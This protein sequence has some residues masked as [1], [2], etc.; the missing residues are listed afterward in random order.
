[1]TGGAAAPAIKTLFPPDIA[2][3]ADDPP[4]AGAAS[5][6]MTQDVETVEAATRHTIHIGPHMVTPHMVIPPEPPTVEPPAQVAEAARATAMTHNPVSADGAAVDATILRLAAERAKVWNREMDLLGASLTNVMGFEVMINQIVREIQP[7]LRG[8]LD[9]LK[10]DALTTEHAPT[11]KSLAD[12]L[13]TLSRIKDRNAGSAKHVMEAWRL[14]QGL[15]Q[16]IKE[17][18]HV[19][20]GAGHADEDAAERAERIAR[21]ARVLSVGGSSKPEPYAGEESGIIDV[22]PV[23]QGVV[24]SAAPAEVVANEGEE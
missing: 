4:A 13:D 23:T 16:Q 2:R 6:P 7:A 22:T 3:L 10:R 8:A 5:R 14:M 9:R 1:M 24:D 17:E 18:R 20:G 11:F 19:G 12:A 15:P 21:M